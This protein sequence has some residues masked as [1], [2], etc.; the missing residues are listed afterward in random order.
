VCSLV[1]GQL[2]RAPFPNHVK[3]DTELARNQQQFLAMSE[4]NKIRSLDIVLSRM[5]MAP[6]RLNL[7]IDTLSSLRFFKKGLHYAVPIARTCCV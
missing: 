3:L 2:L 1:P 7:F 5:E 6:A 4:N